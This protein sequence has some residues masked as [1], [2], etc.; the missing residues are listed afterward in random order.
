MAQSCAKTQGRQ[1]SGRLNQRRGKAF[2]KGHKANRRFEKVNYNEVRVSP[3]GTLFR[4]NEMPQK[5]PDIAPQRRFIF[6]T[7]K[8]KIFRDL[9]EWVKMKSGGRKIDELAAQEV[10]RLRR[11]ELELAW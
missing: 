9:R 1:A 10:M 2:P 4:F 7:Y 3:E 6:W 11:A 5:L 8:C